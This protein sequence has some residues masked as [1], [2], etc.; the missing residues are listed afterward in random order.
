MGMSIL[1]LKSGK[2][3]KP[4]PVRAGQSQLRRPKIREHHRPRT[5]TGWDASLLRCAEKEKLCTRK[6]F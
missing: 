6:T 4:E 5:I 2:S 3:K 1:S